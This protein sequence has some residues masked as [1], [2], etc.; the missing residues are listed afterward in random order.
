MTRLYGIFNL[1]RGIVA[2]GASTIAGIALIAAAVG[3]WIA[4]DLGPLDYARTMRWVI[5]GTIL[6]TLGVQT[7]LSSFF[8]SILGLRRR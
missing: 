4:R 3:Q 7:V 6:V 1:E 5:P 2:G 8:F